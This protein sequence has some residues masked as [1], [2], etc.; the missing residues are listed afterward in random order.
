MKN[1]IC[2]ARRSDSSPCAG[3]NILVL[4]QDVF[5]ITEKSGCADR[6]TCS[7]DQDQIF[8]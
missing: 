3:K 8:S 2:L 5:Q 7:A 6:E 4:L 1:R